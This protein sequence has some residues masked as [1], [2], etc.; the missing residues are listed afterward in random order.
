MK[1]SL[2]NRIRT[3]AIASGL[4]C[5]VA[6]APQ[7]HAASDDAMTGIH[8]GDVLVRLRAIS[9]VPNVDTS[10]TMSALNVSVNNAIVPELDL[11]YMIRD[12]LGVE[13]ILGTSRH[14]LTS[15]IGAL[16]GVNVLPPT[17]L[18]QY[19]FNHAGRV[20]PYVGAGLNY[21]LFYDNGLHAGGQPVS[22]TNHSFGPA[23]QAGVDVQ[24]TKSLFVNA[25]IKKIW[26]HTD[27]SLRG[28]ALGRVS[29]DPVVVGLG[30]GMRF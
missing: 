29:I 16:G 30:V 7:A 1:L 8:A 23:L 15:S 4:L 12:Y 13:L 14:Q 10:G 20:R 28:E 26:M 6:L 27:A 11:T 5:A 21:T 2:R 9:I 25:D 18:L 3:A 24:V 22:I 17:L 19:H